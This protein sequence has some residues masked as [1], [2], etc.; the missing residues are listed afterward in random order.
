MKHPFILLLLV[1]ISLTSCDR[2]LIPQRKMP[3]IIARLHLADRY[4]NSNYRLVLKAD[5]TK[6]YESV[7]NRYGYTGDQFIY[8]IDYYLTRPVKLM[9]FYKEAKQLLEKWEKQTEDLITYNQM[10]EFKLRPYKEIMEKA[11]EIKILTSRERS[12]RW[13]LVPDLYPVWSTSLS[14]S[15]KAIY[16]SPQLALWWASNFKTRYP[17]ILLIKRD[18]KNRST[19]PLPIERMQATPQR[20]PHTGR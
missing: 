10:M 3:E 8:T 11:G 5:T 13:I 18:E 6:I 19:I 9:E 12:L 2:N 7:L 15:L 16:E 20:S 14:D 17:E 1:I 4:V